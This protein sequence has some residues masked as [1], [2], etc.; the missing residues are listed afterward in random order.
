M[1]H[2]YE[3]QVSKILKDK[4]IV[5]AP[6]D[7]FRIA[8]E[9]G[10]Q[11]EFEDLEEDVSGVMVCDKNNIRVAINE[12]HHSNRQRFTLAHEIGHSVLHMDDQDRVF[13]DRRFFR[14]KASSTGE[15]KHE[16]EA[17]AFAADL[18]M[19]RKMVQRYLKSHTN[20][21]D[22]DVYKLAIKFGVSEQAMTLR[23]VRLGYIQPD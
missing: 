14:N 10:M 9:L 12:S 18:L 20:I 5:D 19:P 16:I 7:V 21:Q 13:V 8:G 4:N 2:S 6:V 22:F 23:L 15:L 11:V 1:G 17:N 3:K